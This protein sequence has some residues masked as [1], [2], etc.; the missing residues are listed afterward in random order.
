MSDYDAGMRVNVNSMVLMTKYVIP[1]M[2]RN[3]V[4]RQI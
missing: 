2:E 4:V 3:E 1:H